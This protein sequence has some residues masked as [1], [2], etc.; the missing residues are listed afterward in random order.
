MS[1]PRKGL[2]RAEIARLHAEGYSGR[3]I[4]RMMK[5]GDSTATFRVLNEMKA[6]GTLPEVK[7]K[8]AAPEGYRVK[9]TSSLVD[10]TGAVKL[11]WIK[12][13]EDQEAQRLAQEA[14]FKALAETLKPLQRSKSPKGNYEN[15]ATLYTL[16]DCHV[17]MLAWSRETGEPWDLAIAERVLS[18]TLLHMI[19][20]APQSSLGIV[21]QLGDFLHFD[22]LQPMTPTHHH[23]LDADSRYQKIVEIAVR[24]LRRVVDAALLK[25]DRVQVYM[26]EGNHDP[27][28]SVWL[29][30]MMAAL[31]SNEPR[32]T[33]E[34]SPSPYVAMQW[35]KTMLAFHH[36][37][38]IKKLADL[39][40]L[41]ANRYAKMWGETEFRYCHTG[42]KHHVDEKEHPG[43]KVQQHATLAAPDAYAARGGW[44]SMRQAVS[45]TYSKLH[46]EIAR[47]TFIPVE[48]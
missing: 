41:F 37:H 32:V 6:D 3:A 46:G 38:L 11:Q 42:H 23:I 1:A 16:T 34:Q 36:G 14:A 28:G 47:G 27:S 15:L 24:I 13:T 22:G 31:Y 4:A 20:A 48:F 35:G 39:P 45:I 21:N 17:G 25:H 44:D 40:G 10:E 5:Q 19:E 7:T 9:G 12:T 30:V 43:M 8:L 2:D 33:V 18:D 29:R 26:H